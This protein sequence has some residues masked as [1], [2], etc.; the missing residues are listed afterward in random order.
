MFR[1]EGKN[2]E[3]VIRYARQ[4]ENVFYR[5][6]PNTLPL[7]WFE[8]VAQFR[9]GETDSARICF[10]RA[11][12]LTPWEVRV[13]NDYAASLYASGETAAAKSVLLKT[14]AIDPFFDDARFNLGAVYY[15][16]GQR[17]SAR[18]CIRGCRES[19]KKKDFLE[20]MGK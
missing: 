17:D 6:T 13:L 11:L 18:S 4:A 19:Q 8:G 16:T 2:E 9:L 3:L 20:E 14:L 15:H 7:A 5:I 10:L 1:N 12:A